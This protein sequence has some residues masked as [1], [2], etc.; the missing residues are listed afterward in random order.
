MFFSTKKY[1]K[2]L[3]FTR[4]DYWSLGVILYEM[5]YQTLPFWNASEILA[6]ERLLTFPV[7]QEKD[8]D[9][10]GRKAKKRV[11]FFDDKSS[12]S[13]K[14]SKTS[15]LVAP[16][17]GRLSIEAK[18]FI[19]SLLCRAK[20]R[21]GRGRRGFE[22]VRRH[23]F[24]AS[25]KSVHS[26]WNFGTLRRI[27]VGELFPSLE[28]LLKGNSKIYEKDNKVE[29]SFWLAHNNDQDDDDNFCDKQ[30][31][32]LKKTEITLEQNIDFVGFTN[33]GE[34][35]RKLVSTTDETNDLQNLR[36]EIKTLQEELKRK[37]AHIEQLTCV[38]KQ[39]NCCQL[40]Q[41]YKTKVENCKIRRETFI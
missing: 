41:D 24:F 1:S 38:L 35:Q 29:S 2:V 36:L 33:S 23:P 28:P 5:L 22:E 40:C 10:M 19:R 13:S 11:T 8:I 7:L 12:C 27:P 17:S 26:S 25:L 21:L 34:F 31:S 14:G 30:S 18:S 6:C 15:S 39:V 16:K 32:K 20:Q 37:N 4:R 9:L 3:F